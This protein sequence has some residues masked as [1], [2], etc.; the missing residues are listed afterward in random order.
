MPIAV[1]SLGLETGIAELDQQHKA[2]FDAIN[3]LGEAFQAGQAPSR[4][5]ES[6]AFLNRYTREHFDCE[7]GYMVRSGYPNLAAHQA[8][9]AQLMA[10]LGELEARHGR[11]FLVTADVALFLAEWLT[12]HINEVDM[13]YV[14]YSRGAQATAG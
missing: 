12:H 2:L 11:G 8:E 14:A 13:G 6:L 3:A 7:E 10:R 9:H 5:G 4:V 1:W